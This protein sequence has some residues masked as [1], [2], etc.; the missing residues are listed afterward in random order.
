[1]FSILSKQIKTGE[2]LTEA[3]KKD[4]NEDKQQQQQQ[5]QRDVNLEKLAIDRN[6][7]VYNIEGN[8]KG[9]NMKKSRKRRM[10]KKKEREEKCKKITEWMWENKDGK[11]PTNEN[12]RKWKIVST[13]SSIR[14]ECI[15]LLNDNV[16][17]KSD[18]NYQRFTG[19]VN[20]K[21]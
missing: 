21:K 20:L 2:L 15:D 18:K 10:K 11:L 12:T 1:M 9:L 8:R 14:Q 7:C 19:L 16:D 6:N 17:D 5:P 4:K 13:N 3:H